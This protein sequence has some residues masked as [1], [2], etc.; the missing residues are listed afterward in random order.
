MKIRIP[1]G[2]KCRDCLFHS[3][4]ANS[5]L[6]RCRLF[7]TYKWFEEKPPECLKEFG[8]GG[9]FELTKKEEK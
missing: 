7:E 4:N 1:E 5:F 2:E 3:Y 6:Y 8:N 9:E